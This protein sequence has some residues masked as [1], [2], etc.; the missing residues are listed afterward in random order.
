MSA[1]VKGLREL[2]AHSNYLVLYRETAAL[3]EIVNVVRARRQCPETKKKG[4]SE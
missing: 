1:R 3:V 4:K 2:V